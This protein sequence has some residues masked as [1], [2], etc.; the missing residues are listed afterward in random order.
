MP[1]EILGEYRGVVISDGW[2]AY[3]EFILQRCWAHLL[4]EVDELKGAIAGNKLSS[5]IHLKFRKLKDLLGKDL[6]MEER[7]QI[8]TRLDGEMEELVKKHEGCRGIENPSRTSK[9]VWADGIPVYYTL[10]WSQQTM[11]RL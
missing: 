6:S 1:H 4:R 7:E 8:K 9:M 3:N 10:E 11:S 5:D 2:R